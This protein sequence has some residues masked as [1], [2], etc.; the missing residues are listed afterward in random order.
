[1]A[2]WTFVNSKRERN[3]AR[4][5][6]HPLA[7]SR[8]N[9][10]LKDHDGSVGL[11]PDST[12]CAYSPFPCHR[13]LS[14]VALRRSGFW[15]SPSGT[16]QRFTTVFCHQPRHVRR[17]AA[18]ISYSPPTALAT[19]AVYSF[20]GLS[21]APIRI[22]TCT[23]GYPTGEGRLALRP[24][25]AAKPQL[26]LVFL[27]PSWKLSASGTPGPLQINLQMLEYAM[28]ELLAWG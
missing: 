25:P 8:L 15:T 18:L 17:P 9:Y 20:R 16:G 23:T 24:W 2:P 11:E 3:G 21:G 28:T 6:R 27:T 19:R 14:L 10:E 12:G 1:V 26:R 22:S 7:F 4:S 13:Q 5:W